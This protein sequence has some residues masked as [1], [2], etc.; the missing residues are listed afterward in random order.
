MRK[1]FKRV[2]ARAAQHTLQTVTHKINRNDDG[3]DKMSER[4]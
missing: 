3:D 1:R 2:H 4:Y